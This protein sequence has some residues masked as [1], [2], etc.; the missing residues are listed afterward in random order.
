[1]MIRAVQ[2]ETRTLEEVDE[3]L[4]YLGGHQGTRLRR[5]MLDNMTK[6]DSSAPGG[7]DVTMLKE[8]LRRIGGR[9]E[10]EASGNVTLGES[11]CM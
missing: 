5:V 3:V 11:K 8:A 1:M 4:A 10:T 2:C 7:I 9:I 6:R